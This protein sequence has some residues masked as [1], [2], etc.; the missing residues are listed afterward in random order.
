MAKIKFGN[1]VTDI[2]GSAGDK[3]YSKNKTSNYIKDKPKKRK[4]KSKAKKQ[5]SMNLKD[6]GE[7]WQELSSETK[8][9]WN[10]AYKYPHVVHL[11]RE[12]NIQS[13]CN[14]FNSVNL[15]MT[16]IGEDI[17]TEV[18]QFKDPQELKKAEATITKESRNTEIR[19]F[20]EPLINAETKVIIYA[21]K[22]ITNDTDLYNFRK[23]RKI[24]VLDEKFKNGNSIS[25]GYKRVMKMLPKMGES[26]GIRM[27]TVNKTCGSRSKAYQI[28]SKVK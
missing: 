15:T 9:E 7:V 6:V 19:I 3:T 22:A 21:T 26:I 23:Y 25:K 2:R 14:L 10:R 1:I 5:K 16:E 11:F 17:I 28:E 27:R 20:I 8:R 13:G 18:P 24:E 12:S 4:T